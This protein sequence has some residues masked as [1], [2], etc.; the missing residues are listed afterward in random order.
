MNHHNLTHGLLIVSA[1]AGPEK[2]KYEMKA[3]WLRNIGK[4][5][6]TVKPVVERIERQGRGG[7]DQKGKMR[8]HHLHQLLFT[9]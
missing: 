1:I 7:K 9:I 6:I 3:P 8:G 5:E 2:E 4:S